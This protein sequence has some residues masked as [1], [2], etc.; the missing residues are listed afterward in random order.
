MSTSSSDTSFMDDYN[1]TKNT[2]ETGQKAV[3]AG[4]I[5]VI[6]IMALVVIG[7]L[8]GGCWFC[9]RQRK[10]RAARISEAQKG[11][12]IGTYSNNQGTTPFLSPSQQNSAPYNPT[13]NEAP[14]HKVEPRWEAP[15][16]PAPPREAPNTE[17]K[18]GLPTYERSWRADL[19][20]TAPPRSELQA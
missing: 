16:T 20:E 7:S 14:G 10:R 9:R 3:S 8:I 1:D 4:I 12:N 6:V 18:S 11:F 17:V 5:A 13:Y 15:D 19:G 2:V